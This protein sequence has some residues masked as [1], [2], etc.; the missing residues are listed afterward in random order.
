MAKVIHGGERATDRPKKLF[1]QVFGKE[2]TGKT[3]RGLSFPAPLW[4]VNLD[5]NMDDLLEQLPSHYE[6]H[7]EEVPFDVDMSRGVAAAIM[8]KVKKLFDEAVARGEG[9]FF[10]DGAD[11]YWDYVKA[12]RLPEDAEI[13]NQWGPANSAME[14]FYR[15][16]EACGLQVVFTTIASNVWTGM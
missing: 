12:A 1:L 11:L 2:G 14:S 4:V 10:M 8:L 6:I 15:R 3:S 7:Y 9:T 5:R 13:P 16:A